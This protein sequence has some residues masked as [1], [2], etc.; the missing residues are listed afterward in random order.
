MLIYLAFI[1]HYVGRFHEPLLM[2]VALR[3]YRE[4]KE[5]PRYSDP[6]KLIYFDC[7]LMSLNQLCCLHKLFPQVMMSQ[8]NLAHQ[9]ERFL[10]T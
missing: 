9:I 3:V 6:P 4:F 10:K 1:V 2:H 8:Y 7:S 5:G